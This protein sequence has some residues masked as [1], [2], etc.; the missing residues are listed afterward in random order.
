MA[1]QS[2]PPPA[3]AAE[4]KVEETAVPESNATEPT[5]G[6]GTPAPA[7][8]TKQDYEVMSKLVIRLIEFKDDKY[9]SHPLIP[10]I[11]N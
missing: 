4:I 3:P 2:P 8:L 9:I 6:P 1:S 10:C 7:G 5:S 11:L